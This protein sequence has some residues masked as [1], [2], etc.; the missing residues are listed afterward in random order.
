MP[1]ENQNL[2]YNKENNPGVNELRIII[3]S[4]Y[5]NTKYMELVFKYTSTKEW[6]LNISMLISKYYCYFYYEHSF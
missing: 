6:L 4:K 1:W 5:M 3:T 2:N